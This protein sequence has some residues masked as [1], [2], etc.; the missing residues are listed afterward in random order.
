MACHGLATANPRQITSDDLL[1]E[2]EPLARGR[3]AGG[4]PRVEGV[5]EAVVDRIGQPV[6]GSAGICF[7][8]LHEEHARRAATNRFAASVWYS[9]QALRLASRY[10]PRAL[11]RRMY[12]ERPRAISAPRGDPLMRTLGLDVKYALR[13]NLQRPWLAGLI[14]LMVLFARQTGR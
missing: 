3:L 10:G 4:P 11:W 12:V 5:D 6:G 1:E 9:T 2:G 8:D 7:G 13:S 14:V